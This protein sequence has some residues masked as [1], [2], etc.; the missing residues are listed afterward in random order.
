MPPAAADL[1]R[2]AN[3]PAT[4]VGIAILDAESGALLY[5]HQAE[6]P[7][8]PA[9]TIKTLT[10]AVAL[11]TLGPVFRART[12]L[13][14]PAANPEGVIEGALVLSGRGSVDFTADALRKM[15]LE[16]R[17]AGVRAIH[18]A[19]VLDRDWFQPA[20]PDLGVP[21]FDETPEF[22]YNV[23]PDA[24]L[25]NMN[26]VGLELVADATALNVRLK[27]PMEGVSVAH[28]MKLVDAA[29]ADWEDG[30]LLPEVFKGSG[31]LAPIEIRLRGTFP[32]NCRASTDLN[33]LDRTDFADRLFRTLWRELGG[34][35]TGTVREK[36]ADESLPA[37]GLLAVHAG[38][39]LAE[40][41][42]DINKRSDNP[43]TRVTYLHLGKQRQS[44]G[45]APTA[46]AAERV[47]RDWLRTRQIDDTGL[48][49]DNGS[50]LSR[51]ERIPALTLARV[52][53]EAARG[54]WAPEF[55]AS[56]PIVGVDGAMRTR[57][58]HS[59][60]KEWGRFKTGTL[61]NTTGLV[62]VAP[63]RGGRRL[64]IAVLVNHDH[65]TSRVA[66]PIA[67]SIAEWAI[68]N[69]P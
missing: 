19:L 65:A 61:R 26:L 59:G 12:E 9:S 23:I 3:I 1:L 38:R 52:V 20:R 49:L 40:V 46:A 62:G 37:S 58:A 60:A 44:P 67:D 21:P 50:G 69:F 66:R 5:G 22:Q 29:C 4:A 25:L 64:V 41:V 13:R 54:K 45:D 48:T 43:V 7:L 53:Y 35:F 2:A 32:R 24:L 27:Q 42:R 63:G 57:L 15:L 17:A 68:A 34:E 18:G 33:V 39:T 11:D 8:Q 31:P 16:L 56:L 36:R 51:A 55:L 14:G 6:V 47:V 30:W 28:T 10:S